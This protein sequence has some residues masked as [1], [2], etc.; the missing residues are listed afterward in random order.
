MC[1]ACNIEPTDFNPT[2]IF[3]QEDLILKTY[4]DDID[5]DLAKTW[6][7]HAKWNKEAT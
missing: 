2:L 4:D 6:S 7:G 5:S 3:E 1:S